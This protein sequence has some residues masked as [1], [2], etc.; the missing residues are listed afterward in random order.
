MTSP[1]M[2]D[3]GD[4]LADAAIELVAEWLRRAADPDLH[5]DRRSE[6]QLSEIIEDPAGV[7]FA[8]Q[9]VDRVA[10]PEASRPA[11]HQLAA[12]VRERPLPRFLSPIDRALTWIG[13][14][15]ATLLPSVVIPTAR[16]RMRGLVGHLVVDSDDRILT[17][18]LAAQAA[19]GYRLNVNLLGE[20]V[21]GE[22]GAA[23]R[24][25]ATLALLRRRDVDYASIKISSIASQLDLWAYEATVERI[26]GRLRVLYDAARES[27][28]PKFVNLDMEEYRDLHL[29]IDAFTSVLEEPAYQQL[30]AGIVLQAYLP[31]SFHGLQRLSAWADRRVR[32]GGSDIKIRLVKGANLAMEQV[33]ARLHGWEQAPYATKS[34]TDANYKRCL[35]WLLTPERMRG[36]RA[37]VA[38]HNLFDVAWTRLLSVERGVADRVEFEMLQGM[39]PAQAQ[40]VRDDA[41]GL[42]LYTPVVAKADFD[43]AISYL[44]RRLEENAADDHFIRHLFKLTPH[45]AAFA[46]QADLFRTALERRWSVGDSPRRTQDRT[47]PELALES[48]GFV[49]E[50]DTDPSLPVNRKWAAAAIRTRPDHQS[51]PMTTSVAGV[52]EVVA[53]AVKGQIEWSRRSAAERRTVLWAVADELARRRGD[54]I[55]VMVHEASK[56]VAEADP[57]V[58]EAIDFARYY[59]DRCLELESTDGAAFEP[60][61]V[62][63][64]V[65]P[66][67]F[68]VAIPAGGVLAAL[69]AGNAVVFKPAPETPRCAEL[70]AEA[71]W[72]AGVPRDALQFIRTPDD[73]VGRHLI[74]H[75]DVDGVILTGAFET[76]NLFR[77]WKPDLR[78]FAETS[79]KNALIVSPHA[80]LDLAAADLIRSAFGHSGQKCS[81]ASIGILI[82]DVY[83]SDRFRRQL[84][85]AASSLTLGQTTDPK[86]NIGPVILP[87]AGK[88]ERALT[89][90]DPAET[91]L[92][93]PTNPSADNRLW[94]PGIR[95]G[96]KANSWF[97]LTECF[98][99][100]LGLM[101]ARDLEH[102]VELQNASPYGLTGGIHSLDPAEVERWIDQVDVGNAYVNR[103]ITGAI[104]QRQ[105]FGGWKRS[106]IGPGAK[107]G[108]PN[109][110]SQLGNW[111]DR[112]TLTERAALSRRVRQF[113]AEVSPLI[114]Q[115]D[116]EWLRAAAES[117]QYWWE[118]EF[119][120]EHDPSGLRYESN[121][122][123]YRPRPQV[124]IRAEG[125]GS[126]R[127]L[128]R[129]VLASLRSGTPT[130]I[131]VESPRAVRASARVES[132]AELA[133]RLDHQRGTR[134]RHVGAPHPALRQAAIDAEV[135][136]IDAAPVASGRIELLP[137]LREQAISRTMHRFGE[138]ID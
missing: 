56:T 32:E 13:G 70:V 59:G 118:L 9:F 11:A 37:G 52:D 131:S 76:A 48:A 132:A 45:S 62:V 4:A 91:W 74:T 85:D 8:M 49:N 39:A 136:I 15:I 47:N 127:Q 36:V 108:G 42:L 25:D 126:D 93:E 97:H 14:R 109:Y 88:L 75:P 129:V 110:V 38:S 71:C 116:V 10:R 99:P 29:T 41:G 77:S 26:K 27:Y 5:G 103:H 44:F 107:A 120:V 40:V 83:E 125:D 23:K 57:E 22:V 21:L 104:V 60:L 137:F 82:G 20:G 16:L 86:S 69:A 115:E 78:L 84:V 87:A 67:N 33:E 43:V 73:D 6:Q 134:I 113:L 19:A 24:L 46:E 35:D 106:S 51:T 133:N 135:D 80:D 105:P 30:P 64:V 2:P 92:L 63:A 124:L 128:L 94:T 121:V 72:E 50:P 79:G 18:H 17:R 3:L 58:S 81:A 102:A 122:F 114:S 98:G 31:D 28:P 54:L 130:A 7:A 90:L 117:D 12:L 123:R 34:E 138:L 89:Q 61:G 100:V 1:T 111:S 55:S 65:P 96:V 68:P 66:W 53:T 95:L 101:H 112:G 119:D